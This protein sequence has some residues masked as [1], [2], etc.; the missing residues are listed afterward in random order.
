M[1][2]GEHLG[3]GRL[4]RSR[5]PLYS[6][7]FEEVIELDGVDAIVEINSPIP[8]ERLFVHTNRSRQFDVDPLEGRIRSS[9][10]DTVQHSLSQQVVQRVAARVSEVVAYTRL[11]L[12]G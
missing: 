1:D 5:D 12:T 2:A 6:F 11:D 4:E 8:E 3:K 7:R 10:A 9:H